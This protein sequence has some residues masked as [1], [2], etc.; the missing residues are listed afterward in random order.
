MEIQQALM[1]ATITGKVSPCAKSKR[2]VVI[3]HPDKT[4]FYSA[5]NSPPY[6]F[7]CNGSAECIAACGN[8]A[9]HAEQRAI[10]LALQRENLSEGWQ[11]VHAKVVNGELVAGGQPS[12]IQCSKII[13]ECGITKMWLYCNLTEG[14]TLVSY[15][16]V[17]FHEISLVNSR[18]PVIRE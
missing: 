2:G 12:C 1:L 9:V 6:P 14:P 10:G 16:P 5:N 15:D 8:V 3:F 13:L 11:M 18:L 7:Y 17:T 4:D